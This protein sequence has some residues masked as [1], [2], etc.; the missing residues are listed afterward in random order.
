MFS[1]LQNRIIIVISGLLFINL[2]FAQD[3]VGQDISLQEAIEQTKANNLQLKVADYEIQSAQSDINSTKSFYL[4]Q[5]QAAVTGAVTNLPLNAF[6]SSLQQGAIEQ[7]DFIPASL[8]DPSAITNMQSQVLIQQPLMNLDVK[9]MKNAMVSKS[10]AYEQ[11][12]E[13]TESMLKFQ[14]QQTYLQL[15]LTYE[16]EKVLLKAK[17]TA[18]ANLKLVE[19]N[20][21]AGYL[22]KSD[23]LSVGLRINQ[24]DNQLFEA[25]SNIQNASDQLSFLMGE[26]LGT[27]YTPTDE[28]KDQEAEAAIMAIDLPVDRSDLQAMQYQVEAQE[29]MLQSTQKSKLPRINA[30]GSYEVN[31]PLDFSDAQH[32]FMVAVQASWKIFNGNK[33][34]YAIQKAKIDLEKTQTSLDQMIAQNQLEL[35]RSKRGIL[36]ARNKISLSEKAIEQSK[37]YLRIKTD[38][39]EEG[40]EKTTDLM[41]AETEVAQKEMNY[42]EAVYQ[43]QLAQAQ[44]QFLL[45][46]DK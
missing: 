19:D 14:V 44:L 32:G 16:V 31:N 8:N 30:M 45:E 6:G 12:A 39:F 27:K 3:Q 5:I 46:S 36:D 42:V 23:E 13:R 18:E 20:V 4:P 15:Q 29:H 25:R 43:Y 41:N 24:I 21:E 9:A 7:S 22:H 38:R 35:E 37:E 28:L 10:K 40:L 11:Q 34:K 33:N 26:A 2:S 17:A 1:N